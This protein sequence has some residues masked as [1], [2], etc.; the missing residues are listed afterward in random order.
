MKA[1]AGAPLAPPHSDERL[2]RRIAL[3][4][5]YKNSSQCH[6]AHKNCFKIYIFCLT[7]HGIRLYDEK[8]LKC[9]DLNDLGGDI[10]WTTAK[11]A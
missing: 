7:R 1:A 5:S 4:K 11:D 9:H 3:E 10:P 6:S 8:G 2:F